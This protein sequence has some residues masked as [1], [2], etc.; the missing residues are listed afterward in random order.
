MKKI[1][2]VLLALSLLIPV[3]AFAEDM[4]ME[5]ML[6]MPSMDAP[7]EKPAG[8]PPMPGKGRMDCMKMGKAQ[9]VAADDGGVIILSGNKLLKY[10]AELNLVKEVE[11]P[12]PAWGKQCPMKEKMPERKPEPAAPVVTPEQT[13]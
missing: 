5:D 12:M 10:D 8:M 13:V 11:V 2:L 9:M 6:G 4:E 7:E 3:T 1:V